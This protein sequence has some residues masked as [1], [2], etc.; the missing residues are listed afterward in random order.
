ME[1]SLCR[2]II[3]K[4]CW[5]PKGSGLQSTKE[6]IY[7]KSSIGNKNTSPIYLHKNWHMSEKDDRTIW[8]DSHKICKK[9]V[10][11]PTYSILPSRDQIWCET[12]I[13]QS[14]LIVVD[15]RL[16]T[17]WGL[18]VPY[19]VGDLGQHWF[20]QWLVAWRYQAITRTNVD[21]SSVRSCGI[22]PRTLS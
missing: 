20:R 2:S 9:S 5:T 4:S 21:W 1:T 7:F 22:H 14:K 16:S 15:L 6:I 13:T 17:H 18:L 11:M 10:A 12:V 3:N 8:T 19:G